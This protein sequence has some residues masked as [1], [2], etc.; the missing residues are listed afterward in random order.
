[1]AGVARPLSD[2][3][4]CCTRKDPHEPFSRPADRR[5]GSVLL[6]GGMIEY[7][8]Y[9]LGE[10]DHFISHRAF[11]CQTDVD[12]IVWAKQLQ[13]GHPIELWS[14]E[15]FVIRIETPEQGRLK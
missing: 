4:G 13:D 8:A 6:Q 9:S 2:G 3:L 5:A 7:R 15:R 10:D 1:M 12:A 11:V 14:G